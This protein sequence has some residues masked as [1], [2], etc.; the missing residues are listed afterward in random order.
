MTL[1]QAKKLLQRQVQRSG[2]KITTI[3]IS[4]KRVIGFLEE[5][6]HSNNPS[7]SENAQKLAKQLKE[8]GD[9]SP[10]Q[11]KSGAKWG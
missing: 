7:V 8:G 4:D 11:I 3:S 9:Y 2:D 1:P 5:L 10:L 6:S